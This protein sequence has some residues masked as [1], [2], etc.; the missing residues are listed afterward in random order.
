LGF[1][2]LVLS[3]LAACEGNIGGNPMSVGV[4]G[5]NAGSG[6]G[7]SSGSGTT[8][9]GSTGGSG[10]AGLCV[11]GASFAPARLVLISDDQYR[12]IVHDAFGVTFPTTVDLTTAPNT[13]G[14]FSY[15][16]TSEVETTTVQAY[17]RAA[18]QVAALMTSIPPCTAGA[19]DAGCMEQYLRKTLPRAWRRS[20]TDAEVSGLIDI[21]NSAAMDGQARQVQITM[22]AALL[23]PAFLYRSEIGADAATAT[24]KVPLTAYELA[25]AVSF[26]I[27]DSSPDVELFAKAQDGTLSDPQLL[28][29]QVKRLLT[30]PLVRANLMKKVSYYLSFETLPYAT[31][32]P[33]AYPGFAALQGTLYQSSQMFLNDILWDGRFADLFTSRRIYANEAMA[34]AYNLPLVKGTQL[35]AVTA[36]GD[37]YGAGL[38]S[39]PALLAA[40][41]K[42]AAGDDVIHRGLWVYYNLLCAPVLPPPPPNAASVAAMIMGST[43]EQAHIRD[44]TCGAAC[45]GRFDPFGLVT[46]SYDGIGRFRTTDPTS[47]PP[48]GPL[49]VTATVPAGVLGGSD[50][51]ISLGGVNDLARAFAEGR[52]ISDCAA[53]NLAAYMLAHSPDAEDSCELQTVKNAFQKSGSFSELFSAILTS[54]AFLTRDL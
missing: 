1:L 17:Q 51:A 50:M 54:P 29:A 20:L 48:G 33:M 7:G 36:P 42:N 27:L 53:Q 31:K 4:G 2:V 37:A 39:Q 6:T 52:Q 28:T 35:Q 16:E 19:V 43:R 13:S 25:S 26:A 5:S 14:A 30:L 12:N 41:T 21:F 46:L 9:G 11:Q 44:T 38:L 3:G 22:E 47:T 8:T 40:T 34:S 10:N 49:D 18:D 23:H 24:G 32:D 15:N 45:H